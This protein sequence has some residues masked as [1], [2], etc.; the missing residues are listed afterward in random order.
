M[1]VSVFECLFQI[2]KIFI[3]TTY[4]FFYRRIFDQFLSHM[5]YLGSWLNETDFYSTMIEKNTLYQ[6]K[7]P[8][9]KTR[10]YGSPLMDETI[11]NIKLYTHWMV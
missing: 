6:N 7:P 1:E 9:Q 5:L 4:V 3:Q 8:P 10:L 2:H 11:K